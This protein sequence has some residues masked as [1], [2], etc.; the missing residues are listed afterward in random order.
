MEKQYEF[1][2]NGIKFKSKYGYLADKKLIQETRKDF[3]NEDKKL[4]FEQ[5][6]KCLLEGKNRIN[7]INE[8]YFKRIQNDTIVNK[9]RCSV[10]ETLEND[11]GISYFINL[12]LDK[13]KLY[14]PEK[15]KIASGVK[16]FM[17]LG[18]STICRMPSNFSLKSAK[19]LIEKYS[20]SGVYLDPCCGWGVRMIAAASLNMEYIGFDVSH[21]L[22]NK[23]NE[24][25][26]DIQKIKPEFKFKVYEQGSQYYIDDLKE[27]ADIILTSPPYY[28]L[29]N[30]NH[31]EKEKNDTI[32]NKTYEDWLKEFVHPM[33]KNCY[34]YLKNGSYCLMNVKDFKEYTL[35]KDFAKI[36]R[37]VG[38][39]V[40][41]YDEY[42]LVQRVQHPNSET[43]LA[44]GKEQVIVLYKE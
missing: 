10:N 17:R 8:Y 3:Y 22:I 25:G 19:Q 41:G 31:R 36:G 5:L 39:V 26:K 18:S 11:Y 42:K 32:E 35:V 21:P 12:A 24:L 40:E 38:F 34:K 9:Y 30:Y 4:A 28:N 44:S 7:Y 29:E 6:K 27:K 13:P 37:E 20:N 16:T 2:I 15:E 14:N 23:L 43:K 33:L 1:E